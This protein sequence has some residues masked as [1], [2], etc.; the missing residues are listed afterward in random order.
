MAGSAG[1]ERET[2]GSI[3]H[4]PLSSHT[5]DVRLTVYWEACQAVTILSQ[6]KDWVTCARILCPREMGGVCVSVAACTAVPVDPH[7]AHALI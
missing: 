7:T 4:F 1:A 5:N 2:Q 6:C 3:A